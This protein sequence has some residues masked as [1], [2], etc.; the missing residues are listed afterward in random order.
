MEAIAIEDVQ[1]VGAGLDAVARVL[2]FGGYRLDLF[3]AVWEGRGVM[4]G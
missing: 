3:A 2:D 1:A 4:D